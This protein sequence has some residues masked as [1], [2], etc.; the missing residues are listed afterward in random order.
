MPSVGQGNSPSAGTTSTRYEQ[1]FELARGGMASLHLA[2]VRGPSG[3]TKYVVLKRILPKW[4]D[5]A[6]FV[7]MFLDEARLAALLDHPNAVHVYD[8][9]RDDHGPFFAMEYIHGEDVRQLQ[10]RLRARGETMPLR[11]AVAIAI[12]AAAGLHHAHERYDFDGKPLHII[13]RDV[14]PSNVLVTY[15]GGI[16]VV[17]FGI[18]KASA[19]ETSTRPS[20]RK[21][22]ITFM[23]PEQCR[24]DAL[25]RR[26]DVFALGA[27]L[28]Q[29]LTGQPVFGGDNEFAVMNRIVNH[30]APAPSTLRPQLPEALDRI[31]L[32]AL[33]RDPAQR[34]ATA[35]EL[36]RELEDLT[37]TLG[38]RPSAT[39]LGDFVLELSGGRAYPWEGLDGGTTA[40]PTSTIGGHDTSAAEDQAGDDDTPTAAT[41]RPL[42]AM[43]S[44]PP[45]SRRRV[46][47]WLLASGLLGAGVGAWVLVGPDWASPNSADAAAGLPPRRTPFQTPTPARAAVPVDDRAPS[48]PEDTT[49][50]SS[51]PAA[52]DDATDATTA[53]ADSALT[54]SDDAPTTTSASAD[55][56][57]DEQPPAAAPTKPK[58]RRPRNTR[59][60]KTPSASPAPPAETPEPAAREFDPDGPAPRREPK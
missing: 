48:M 18:A 4:A 3:F 19:R 12:G 46:L 10:R 55:S 26:S 28:H 31:V 15:E 16:K 57:T 60:R 8:A 40:G 50:S 53:D 52:P 35:R 13:H 23:S 44:E 58:R 41:D 9:G 56:N 51:A 24:G 37:E 47:P 6:E 25:D 20:V 43:A 59:P 33:S 42:A 5:E 38:M 14:S 21:G 22:K 11:H 17:D 1:L 45:P 49:T 54:A 27:V 36:Q 34:H 29:M 30:D 7:D 32:R 2:R 39:A